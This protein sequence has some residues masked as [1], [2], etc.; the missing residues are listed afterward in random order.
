M[1]GAQSQV[2]LEDVF[3]LSFR[4][5]LSGLIS[6]LHTLGYHITGPWQKL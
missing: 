5:G 4:A 1:S 3:D 2:A 6:K